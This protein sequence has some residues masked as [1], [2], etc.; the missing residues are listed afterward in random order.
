VNKEIGILCSWVERINIVKMSIPPK[1]MYSFNA[2]STQIPMPFFTKLEPIIQNSYGT[3]KDLKL[4][5][6]S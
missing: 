4:L 1:A 2:I 3:T 5:K 6:P